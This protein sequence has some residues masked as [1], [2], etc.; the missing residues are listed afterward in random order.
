MAGEDVEGLAVFGDG[1]A[2]DLD[3]LAVQEF[4][5]FVVAE[6]FGF[7]LV[8]DE[9]SDGVFDAVVAEV[10]TGFGAD[11]VGEEEFEFEDAVRGGDVFA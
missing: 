5:E 6:G 3:A 7:D 1:A 10:L 9:F 8:F 4:G 11:A 2:G